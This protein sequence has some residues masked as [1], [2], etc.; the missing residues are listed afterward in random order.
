MILLNRKWWA[1]FK[2]ILPIFIYE[3]SG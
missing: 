1:E 2:P 3:L